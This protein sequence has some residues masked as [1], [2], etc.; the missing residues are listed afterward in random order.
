MQTADY[1]PFQMCTI[2]IKLTSVNKSEEDEDNYVYVYKVCIIQSLQKIG[3]GGN[4]ILKSFIFPT[5]PVR[6]TRK[7]CCR[8][9]LKIHIIFFLLAFLRR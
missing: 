7:K 9:S 3:E 1:T 8:V 6:K 4:C 5:F 2:Y